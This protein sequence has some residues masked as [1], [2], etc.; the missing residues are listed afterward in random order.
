MAGKHSFTDYI[1]TTYSNQLWETVEKYLQD[2]WDPSDY[3]FR[4]LH[5]VGTPEIEDVSVQHIWVADRPEMQ[6]QFDVAVSVELTVP[7]ANHHYDDYEEKTIWL[8]IRCEGDL[9]KDLEDF[10]IFEVSSYNGK[11]RIRN[12]L[13]DSLVPV[14]S[15]D[16]LEEVAENFLRH[17]YKKALLE[18]CWVDPIGYRQELCANLILDRTAC[19]PDTRPDICRQGYTALVLALTADVRPGTLRSAV[20]SFAP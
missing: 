6:I 16:R 18:P 7:D 1:A 3:D 10:N 9:D 2:E 4:K 15:R 5:R 13:D 17:H 19:L 11:N 8:M 20:R 14:I 12:A